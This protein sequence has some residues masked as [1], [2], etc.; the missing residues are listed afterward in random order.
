[1]P[2]IL[3]GNVA[4]ATA[5]T[6]YDVV[7]SCRFND[8]DTAYMSK[9][10]SGGNRRTYTISFWFKKG[11]LSNDENFFHSYSAARD[12]LNV[13][14]RGN[15]DIYIVGYSDSDSTTFDLTSA[16]GLFRDPAAWYHLVVAVDTTQGTAAN[17]MKVYING[18]QFTNWS[19]T[20]SY[21][22]ENEQTDVNNS[23]STFTVGRSEES[24]GTAYYDGYIAE[25]CLIDGSALAPTSFGE[26][27]E[28]SPTIWKPIDVSGLT[29]GT[30]GFYLDFEDSGN[31]GNDA[32][33]G[34]DFTETNLAAAD[35]A[36]DTPTNNFATWNPLWRWRMDNDTVYS[37]G[38]VKASWS[39]GSDR[40]FA[41]ATMG[42]S[43]GKWYW[44][45][46]LPT[47]GRCFSGVGDA[48]KVA[49]FNNGPWDESGS[50]GESYSLTIQ[51][52][53]GDIQTEGS[54]ET[55]YSADN[56]DDDICMWALDMDNNR[57]WMG[58]NGTWADSGDPTSGATGTGDITTQIGTQVH[59]TQSE[60]M[61]PCCAD[62]STAG[63]S[64]LEANFGGCPSF[65]I[66]SGNADAN[67]YGNFEYAPPSGFYAL[68]TK[69]LAEFG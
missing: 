37:E 6:T 66:S 27:D 23:G 67:G 33:G 30:N 59:L 64:V 25:F 13:K 54:T 32:N 42:V 40:G 19:G 17:R 26:F 5:A 35:Q 39:T 18:V 7:N 46:K 50:S 21:P 57:L 10:Q 14:S 45:V 8:P 16:G 68:C 69:N 44:E 58:I 11:L 56:S 60:V 43:K 2:L 55:A 9:T 22:A 36:T 34:T 31:L 29:F 51:H 12:Q 63:G 4:S 47:V 20:P 28:D 3:P 1:M 24:T 53:N 38:N 41:F 15:D 49:G 48:E 65:A 62:P 61:T 52:R